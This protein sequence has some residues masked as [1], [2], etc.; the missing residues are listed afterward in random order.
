MDL[1]ATVC[2]P[3]SPLCETCPLSRQC[4]AFAAGDPDGYPR[5]E[6]KALRPHRHGVAYLTV[7]DGRVAL[8]RRPA[9]GLLGGMLGLPTTEWRAERW[10]TGE[11]LAAATS[12]AAWRHVG[13]VAHA[14][15]HFSLTL[16]VYEANEAVAPEDAIWLPLE[17]ALAATP[18]VFRKALQPLQASLPFV[19]RDA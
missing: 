13:D 1:G 16:S 10:S 14:I 6:A 17:E 12:P 3:S 19:S 7:R 11:A 9:K 2:R 5:K 15:T 8:V 18:T 4:A